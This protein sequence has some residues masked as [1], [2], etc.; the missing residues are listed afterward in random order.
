MLTPSHDPNHILIAVLHAGVEVG[1]YSGCVQAWRRLQQL[2][3]DSVPARAERGIAAMEE[4]LQSY[5]LHSPQVCLLLD[6]C[7][8]SILHKLNMWVH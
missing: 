2:Q 4:L 3:P 5:P 1:Y 7:T 8:L 6:T